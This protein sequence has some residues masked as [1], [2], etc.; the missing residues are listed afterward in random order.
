MKI[1]N[2]PNRSSACEINKWYIG[3]EIKRYPPTMLGEGLLKPH[4]FAYFVK[5]TDFG[6]RAYSQPKKKGGFFYWTCTFGISIQIV[7]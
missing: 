7:R 1:G 2:L 5:F 4:V 3:I 6:E